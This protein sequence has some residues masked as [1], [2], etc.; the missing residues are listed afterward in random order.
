MI[1]RA[2]DSLCLGRAPVGTL[3]VMALSLMYPCSDVCN[4]AGT[5]FVW[6]GKVSFVIHTDRPPQETGVSQLKA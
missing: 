3:S 6:S 4:P 5:V 2:W 1:P